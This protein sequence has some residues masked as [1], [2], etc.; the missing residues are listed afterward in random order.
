MALPRMAQQEQ[1]EFGCGEAER[2]AIVFWWSP[3]RPRA[4]T[5]C[6]E[7]RVGARS[8]LDQAPPMPRVGAWVACRRRG[9]ACLPKLA[10]ANGVSP[11]R[12]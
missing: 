5:V 8:R 11:A 4:R 12:R 9:S 3:P 7:G 6:V 2:L 10:S 1:V